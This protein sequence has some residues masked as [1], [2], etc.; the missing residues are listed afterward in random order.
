MRKF[1]LRLLTLV[2][3]LSIGL[4]A[5]ENKKWSFFGIG[6]DTSVNQLKSKGFKCYTHEEC[7]TEFGAHNIGF[8]ELE[9]MRIYFNKNGKATSMRM[10]F[11]PKEQKSLIRALK[12]KYSSRNIKLEFWQTSDYTFGMEVILKSRITKI[13]YDKLLK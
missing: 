11:R 4:N 6:F 3:I 5:S 10:I 8:K 12:K 7:Q 1:I 2:L 13:K 9:M